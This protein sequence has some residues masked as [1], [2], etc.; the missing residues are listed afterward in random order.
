MPGSVTVENAAFIAALSNVCGTLMPSSLMHSPRTA[1][2]GMSM[3]RCAA[4]TVSS[5]ISRASESPSIP[6]LSE[7]AASSIFAFMSDPFF[8]LTFGGVVV[9]CFSRYAL[10]TA[11]LTCSLF[12]PSE[13][14]FASISGN[15]PPHTDLTIVTR[16][17]SALTAS[18]AIAFASGIWIDGWLGAG[19]GAADAAAC[20]CC[21]GCAAGAAATTV[22]GASAGCA[23]AAAA[24]GFG[25]SA[26]ADAVA[27]GGVAGAAAATGFVSLLVTSGS[28]MEFPFSSS[29]AVTD[30]CVERS[31]PTATTLTSRKVDLVTW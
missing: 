1:R 7:S 13:M 19:F 14:A 24:T 15:S 29:F 27:V 26:G 10:S 25:L 16:S 23:G 9:G 11:S 2:S 12:H 18:A 20:T 22:L 4:S 8:T 17:R 28:M 31:A 3:S 6:A 30:M 5:P 21:A